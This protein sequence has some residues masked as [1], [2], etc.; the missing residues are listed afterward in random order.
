MCPL[1]KPCA[2]LSIIRQACIR[3][4]NQLMDNILS[5][6][7]RVKANTRNHILHFIKPRLPGRVIYVVDSCQFPKHLVR[8][9]QS[10]HSG[11]RFM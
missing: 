8:G 9:G 4:F 6:I 3:D 10:F 5:I 2:R 7:G 11:S 1:V